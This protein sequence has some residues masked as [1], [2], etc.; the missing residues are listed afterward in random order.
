MAS[1]V[2]PLLKAEY[3]DAKKG[4]QGDRGDKKKGGKIDFSRLERS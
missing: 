2:S 4:K 3:S 1:S